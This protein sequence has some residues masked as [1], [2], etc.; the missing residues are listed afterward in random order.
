MN[1]IVKVNRQLAEQFSADLTCIKKGTALAKCR[2]LINLKL[3][4]AL[5]GVNLLLGFNVNYHY[6]A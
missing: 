2:L 1:F 4:F 6:C 3:K 5:Q